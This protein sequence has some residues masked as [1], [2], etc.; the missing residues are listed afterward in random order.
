MGNERRGS[1][2]ES[3]TNSEGT[4][5]KKEQAIVQVVEGTVE[6][7]MRCHRNYE[8]GEFQSKKRLSWSKSTKKSHH[9]H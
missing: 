3:N 5:G 9:E 6:V 2:V 1:G 7:E 4:G 8:R